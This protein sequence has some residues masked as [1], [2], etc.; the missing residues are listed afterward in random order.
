MHDRRSGTDRSWNRT[1]KRRLIWPA[2]I[3]DAP[4]ATKA[5]WHDL[6][7][8]ILKAMHKD[9]DRRYQSVEALIRDI[10]HYL[11]GKPLEARSDSLFYTT[12]KFVRRNR[13]TVL[14][15][16][17][18]LAVIV[19]VIAFFT[20]RLAKARDAALAEA[21]RTGRVERFMLN[22]I[23]GGDE[24]VGPSEDLRVVTLLERGVKEVRS[25][26][27]DPAIQADLYQTLATVYQSFGKFDQAEPLMNSALQIRKS[28]FGPDSQETADAL[29][30]LGLLRY[31]QG[32][33]PD[34]ERLI[35][36]ALAMGRRHIPASD[37]AVARALSALGKV[38]EDAGDYQ[39]AIEVLQDAARIQS[40]KGE[41]GIDLSASLTLLAN[42]HFYLGH[43][44]IADSLNQRVLTMDKQ[45]HGEGHPDVA[46]ALV[47]LG[48]VQTNLEHY[49]AAERY[50]QQALEIDRSW[51]GKDH[52]NTADIETYVAQALAYEKRHGEAQDLLKHALA[53]F[54]RTYGEK[55]NDRVA[56]VYGELGKIAQTLGHL[57]ESERDFR[58]SVDI[59]TSTHGAN[60][61]FVAVELSNLGSVYRDGKRYSQAEQIFREVVRRLSEALPA[62]HLDVA[63]AQVKLGDILV[64]ENRYQEAEGHLVAGY[65]ILRKQSPASSTLRAAREDLVAV[66]V[67]LKMPEKAAHFRAELAGSSPKNGGGVNGK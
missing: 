14:A 58:K 25:L 6:D 19:G 63:V 21:A 40:A 54:E 51:Y 32:R 8:L 23:Q 31:D 24:E 64:G 62:D 45:V 35:R 10:G 30:H 61:S 7:A 34:A 3:A 22:L 26:N 47:N 16:S 48:N 39:K 5:E 43:Y 27:R 4:H 60:H 67:S 11:T 55:P 15:A 36:D 50:F 52:P 2:A 44:T 12:G 49:V 37:P 9:A 42:A 18:V 66:Y 1:L 56:M 29:L 33:L 20:L 57:D 28:V 65:E 59:Y 46:D 41:A 38:L 53:V 17:I 13:R